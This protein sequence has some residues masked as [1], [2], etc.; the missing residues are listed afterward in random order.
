MIFIPVRQLARKNW[1]YDFKPTKEVPVYHNH[2]GA[3]RLTSSPDS[4]TCMTLKEEQKKILKVFEM[5]MDAA[6]D[7]CDVT[8]RDH[9]ITKFA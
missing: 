6:E 2:T 5:S 4:E 9:F 7:I 8:R 3:H 1:R